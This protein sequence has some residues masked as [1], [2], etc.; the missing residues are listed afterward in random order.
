LS[1]NWEQASV[2]AAFV[3][4]KILAAFDAPF[5]FD[6]R[7]YHTTPSIDVALFDKHI[8]S[9]DEVLKHADMA[10]YQAKTSGR[11]TIPFFNPAMQTVISARGT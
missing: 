2:Q 9:V 11:N 10:M 1:A 3:A 4:N 7:Q 5:Q 8:G 6:E